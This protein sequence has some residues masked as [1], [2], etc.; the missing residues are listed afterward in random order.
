[1]RILS[2]NQTNNEQQIKDNTAEIQN[3]YAKIKALTVLTVI[4]LLA[5]GGLAWWIVAKLA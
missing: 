5:N 4:S 2:D 1:M 3:I